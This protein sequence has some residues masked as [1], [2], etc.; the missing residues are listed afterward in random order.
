MGTDPIPGGR[1]R[2][3]DAALL[4]TRGYHL[5]AQLLRCRTLTFR[6]RSTAWPKMKALAEFAKEA[7]ELPAGKRL[8]LARILLD[9]SDDREIGDVEDSEA[10]WDDVIAA[11]IQAV[12]DG[13][14]RASDLEDVIARFEQRPS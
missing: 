3:G 11:R 2:R 5:G 9:L 10:A 12:K 4:A 1:G 14:A 6:G 13:R 7:L 8:T